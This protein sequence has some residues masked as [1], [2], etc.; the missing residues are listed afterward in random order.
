M[1]LGMI[2]LGRLGTSI[3]LNLNTCA[4]GSPEHKMRIVT[5]LRHRK[6]VA[7]TSDGVNAALAR[8]RADIGVAMGMTG[9]EVTKIFLRGRAKKIETNLTAQMELA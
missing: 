8:K 4:R 5:S 2:G 7:I 3:V 1:Q 9:T 6:V